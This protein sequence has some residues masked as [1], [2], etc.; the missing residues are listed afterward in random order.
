MKNVLKII[1]VLVLAYVGYVVYMLV[2]PS[3]FSLNKIILINYISFLKAA[4][5]IRRKVIARLKQMGVFQEA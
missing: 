3:F 1:G 4:L 5:S 2:N